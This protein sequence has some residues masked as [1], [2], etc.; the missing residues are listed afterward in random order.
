MEAR[1]NSGA[2]S[3]RSSRSKINLADKN[4][5]QVSKEASNKLFQR[6]RLFTNEPIGVSEN[7]EPLSLQGTKNPQPKEPLSLPTVSRHEDRRANF[8]DRIISNSQFDQQ[9]E[10]SSNSEDE[11]KHEHDHDLT[12]E[13][14]QNITG[15]HKEQIEFE[16]LPSELN[17]LDRV[18]T[19]E[20]TQNGE[21]HREG[22]DEDRHA[23]IDLDDSIVNPAILQ[24]RT[25]ETPE[26]QERNL[27]NESDISDG[28]KMADS[29]I[30]ILTDLFNQ[31][32]TKDKPHKLLHTR[33]LPSF[34]GEGHDFGGGFPVK[35]RASRTSKWL[36]R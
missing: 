31:V 22:E 15:S 8:I 28:T 20:N 2:E 35:I 29:S 19:P 11:V 10:N 33:D 24:D 27:L 26:Q 32:L 30:K 14:T 18:L 36:G 5:F 23:L 34:R 4:I 3:M 12:H 13:E 25:T 1:D 17:F 21:Y 7:R 6:R 9:P 16:V